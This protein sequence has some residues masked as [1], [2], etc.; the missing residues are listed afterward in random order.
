[1]KKFLSLMLVFALVLSLAACGSGTKEE[2][3]TKPADDQQNQAATEEI[4]PEEGAKLVLWESG[5]KAGEWAK[6]VASEFEKK[7]GVPVKYEEVGRVDAPGKLKTDGPAGLGADVFVAPHDHL[8][9]LISGGLI[10]ENFWPEEYQNDFMDAAITGTTSDGV[11]Y[12]YPTAIQT[13]ALFYNKDLVKKI[14]ETWDELIAQSKEFTDPKAN[15]YGF[16]M[17]V[18][19]FYFVYSLIGGYD[20]YVFGQN[21]TDPS[22]L[23]IN[24]E[25]AIKAGQLLQR[26]H[27]EIL[28]LK[29]EDMTYDV[30]QSLFN[31]G[32]L[33]FNMDGPWAVDAHRQAGVN[34]GVAPLPKL[35]NGKY[36]TSFS[37][38]QAAFVNAYTKY[39]NAASLLAK[40]MSSEEM[41]LKFYEMTGELPPRKSLIEK[42]EIK[43]NE[44]TAGFLK[45]AERSIP[46]P[47]IPEMQSVWTPAGAAFVTI[48]NDN[49][50]VKTALD[51][52]V[53][54]IKEGIA[55]QNTNK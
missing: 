49:T 4:K 38:I 37:G 6:F 9:E 24:S 41:L 33:M 28:P 17:E 14:P 1:M 27:N 22:D 7:Y 40:F 43:D 15:K 10:L 20:G 21:N 11:L 45:Q 47:N 25:G 54:Q 39:P 50:D 16:M 26:I 51:A 8:G 34:F 3:T 46:M 18:G 35:D 13:Y 23:G 30:K 31:E 55:T 42:P 19:N 2:P 5:D 48:W 36:P 52:A 29:N 44:I 32:K 53:Q 12:G